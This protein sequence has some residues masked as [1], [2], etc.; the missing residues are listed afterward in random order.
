[1]IKVFFSERQTIPH[2]RKLVIIGLIT[3]SMALIAL[4]VYLK[5]WDSMPDEEKPF[6]LFLLAGPLSAILI[7]FI[8][9]ELRI[10]YD[11]IE[12]RS[13]PFRKTFRR[14]PMEK[15]G[16][17]ELKKITG[18]G[19]FRNMGQNYK[20]KGQEMYYGARYTL[21]VHLK[22]GK[23]LLFGTDKPM[24]LEHFLSNLP[25]GGPVFKKS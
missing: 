22:D 25:E 18:M 11:A 16:S 24:E 21:T 10:S 9:T 8:G 3:L 14:V 1:M 6:L 17:I 5:E 12:Y 7:F 2:V 20:V 4:L 23:Y 19:R 13:M 15:I